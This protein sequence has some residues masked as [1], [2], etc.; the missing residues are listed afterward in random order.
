MVEHAVGMLGS[1]RDGET[2]DVHAEMMELTLR[3]ACATLFGADV[4]AD[5]PAVRA[6][7]LVLSAHFQSRLSS[8]LFLLPDRVPT[9]GNLRYAAAVRTLDALVYRIIAQRRRDGRDRGDLL[10]MLLGQTPGLQDLPRLR[11]LGAVVSETLRLYPPAYLIGREALRDLSIGGYAVRRGS[12]VLMSQYVVQRDRRWFDEPD[13]FLPERW[14]DGGLVRELPRFAYFPFGGGQR[15]CI[16]NT[17]AQVEANLL[18]GTLA[19]RVQL[20][21][22]PGHPVVPQAVVTLRPRYGIRMTVTRAQADRAAAAP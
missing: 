15:Q 17:F 6:A 4:S 8:L 13:S 11:Y 18:L 16:G 22:V 3:I 2:R 12:T 9:P 14:L 20:R 5:L 10:S 7:N 19:Q 1:W 21:L